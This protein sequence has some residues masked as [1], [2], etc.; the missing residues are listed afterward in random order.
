MPAK[1][2][3]RYSVTLD[4]EYHYRRGVLDH[5]PSRM[6]TAKLPSL[7][8][9]LQNLHQLGV[10]EFVAADH[11]PR[12]QRIV[13]ALDARDNAAG[14]AHDD[15]TRRHVPG[16]QIAL[17]VAVEASGGDES[18]IQRGGAEAAQ[19]RDLVLDCSHLQ[20]REL[21]IAA[22]DMR[23]AAGD[24]AFVQLA[25]AGDA[26]PLVVEEG[27]LAALG[28]VELFV[29]RIVDHAGNDGA[30]TLQ[31]DRDRE[32]RDAVQ[33]IGGA[34][35]RIDDPGV[36]LVGAGA[37]AAFLTE[38]TVTRPGLVKVGVEHFLGALVGERD[39][40]GRALQRYLEVLDLA[41]V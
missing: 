15:L 37:V 23:Q 27:A 11:M 10:H 24:D 8:Q 22:A 19:A 25:A 39:E 30:L 29:G 17:P 1:A 26:Q 16:L 18:H 36:A 20:P 41:E 38:E 2:G 3:I 35:E 4:L 28:D 33:E 13:V 32:L 12:L 6:M 7:P 9:R 5:P 14:F 21:M 34:V 40:I 31:R